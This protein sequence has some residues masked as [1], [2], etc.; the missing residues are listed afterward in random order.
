M[1]FLHGL[2]IFFKKPL[3]VIILVSFLVAWF[4][5]SFGYTFI[6]VHG[7]MLF[8]FFFIGF[9]VGFTFL[10]F[11]ISFFKP[12]E[13]LRYF[14]IILIFLISIPLILIFKGFLGL[15]SIGCLII[16]QALTAFFA[17]KLCIDT[18]TKVD[19]FFYK[20]ENSRK[21]TRSLEFVIFGFIA[22]MIYI[23]TWNLLI[24]LTPIVAIRS[25]RIF[26]IIFWVNI[27]LLVIVIIRTLIIRKFAAYITLFFILS[28]IYILYI[29]IDT[30]APFIFPDAATY[31]WYYF[32]FD[33]VLFIYSIGSIFDKI[34]YLEQKF[35][36][37]SAETISFFVILIKLVA[38]YFKVFPNLPGIVVPYDYLLWVQIFLLII[39]IGCILF[40]GIYSIFAHK[41][42]MNSSKKSKN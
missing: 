35:K 3:Y 22:V 18:S 36:I 28:F 34:E 37:L 38:Q 21:I 17:F 41:E 1:S 5:V 14:L 40:F 15:F 4:L 19:D 10:L 20:N 30:I 8:V 7:Y 16:N 29:I 33:L 13:K 42:G 24:R 31:A 11:I 25:L 39:F 27:V 2:K 9:L 6:P 32:I 23:I 12:I 26:R